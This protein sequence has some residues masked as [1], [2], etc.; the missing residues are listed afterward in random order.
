MMGTG[1]MISAGWPILQSLNRYTYALDNPLRY[2][3]PSG[4]TLVTMCWE[5]SSSESGQSCG[6]FDSDYL[7]GQGFGIEFDP[8]TGDV[9]SIS[10]PNSS[11]SLVDSN[12]IQVGVIGPDTNVW[13]STDELVQS[14]TVSS[15]PDS[16]ESGVGGSGFTSGWVNLSGAVGGPMASSAK[17]TLRAIAR[18]APTICG[19]GV[20]GYRGKGVT[21]FG[22]KAFTG[23]I[24]EVDSRS[25]ASGGL[26]HEVGFGGVGLG[27]ITS[28]GGTQGLIFGEVL[29]VPGVAAVGVV[30]FPSGAG[31]YVEGE[32]DG[33]EVGGGA[34]LNLTTIAGCPR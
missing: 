16:S 8:N 13:A 20:F 14:I 21:A 22:A 28:S 7:A 30:G 29:E 6:S 9:A 19:G 10:P 34:Y 5:D 4:L 31:V 25:G 27:S 11:V 32:L 2:T 15:S 33:R 26:L 24:S 23:V 17:A 12:G 3:D 1:N 18:A